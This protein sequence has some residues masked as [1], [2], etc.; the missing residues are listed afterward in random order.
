MLLKS[1]PIAPTATRHTSREN[2]SLHLT[3]TKMCS[4]LSAI[5]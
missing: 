5:I 2:L 4:V 1:G 3:P